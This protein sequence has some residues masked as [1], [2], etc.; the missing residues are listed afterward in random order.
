MKMSKYILTII[1]MVT[2][3]FLWQSCGQSGLN[4]P[5]G[6]LGGGV[7]GYGSSG[8]RDY[9]GGDNTGDFVGTS[10]NL[11]GTRRYEVFQDNYEFY[12]F[13]PDGRY[14]HGVQVLDQ[15]QIIDA[16]TYEVNG[17][18]ITFYPTNLP[19]YSLTFLISGNTLTL[20]DTQYQ[21]W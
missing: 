9:T 18:T 2:F 4:N 21:R 19:A 1:L 14:Q 8:I 11:I 20:G 16:G 15:T 3:L 12:R 13:F 10:P 5:F 17:N 7:N 6:V